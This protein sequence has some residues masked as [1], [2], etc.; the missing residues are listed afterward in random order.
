V[1]HNDE[2][3][4]L[5]AAVREAVARDGH[6]LDALR[7]EAR[8]LRNSVRVIQPRTATTV[9]LVASDG[10]NHSFPLDPFFV[11][12]VRV[13]DSYG[14]PLCFDVVTPS[15]DIDALNARQFEPD[16]RP[17]TAIGRMILDLGVS[18]LADLSPAI[19]RHLGSEPPSPRDIASGWVVTYRDLCEWATLYERICYQDFPTDTVL[20]RDGL[21]RAKYFSGT[22]F[23]DL[24]A[25]IE[26]RIAAL[27]EKRRRI[28][29]VGIAKHSKILERYGLAF[30]IE[31][32]F[33][34]GSACYLEV[35][36]AMEKSV[37]RWSEY[38]R[39]RLDPVEED[40]EAAKF[41][42]GKMFLAR[43]GKQGSDPI[44]PVDIFE[45]QASQAQE[46]LGYLLQDAING[47]PV[48][49]YPRSLQLA[50]EW[51]EIAGFDAN[52][53]ADAMRL[54]ISDLDPRVRDAIEHRGL[55][56]ADVSVQRYK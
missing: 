20:I 46:I 44:W 33:P 43:F 52:I 49:F 32:T 38:A 36:R 31:G 35:T 12:V 42:N 9:S 50:H 27:K 24:G 25:K 14:L 11:Q 10:G 23:T 56:I 15:T 53:I 16:G 47:F 34:D 5:D 8:G 37:Y 41:V 2:I 3:A 21:L 30:S 55:G 39:G 48:P 45:P 26:Q 28:F 1:L 19:P 51:A 6:L 18:H 40:A 4:S 22:L 13:V 7:L 17:R 29:L 54:A